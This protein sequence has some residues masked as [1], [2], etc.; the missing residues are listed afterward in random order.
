MLI[1]QRNPVPVAPQ[2]KPAC[3]GSQ[4]ISPF[5]NVMQVQICPDSHDTIPCAIAIPIK[6]AVRKTMTEHILTLRRHLRFGMGAGAFKIL[7]FTAVVF[8]FPAQSA[9]PCPPIGIDAEGGSVVS[10]GTSCPGPTEGS[11]ETRNYRDPVSGVRLLTGRTTI[12]VSNSS[13]LASA[14]GAAACGQTIQ[15]APGSYSG[16]FRLR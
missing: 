1:S 5:C 12:N 15:L 11:S 6:P 4:R 13:Q 10:A 7:A 2:L 8:A 3:D 14:L 16:S 9:E